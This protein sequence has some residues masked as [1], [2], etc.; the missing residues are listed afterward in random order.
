MIPVSKLLPSFATEH[1][2][3]IKSFIIK[4]HKW[5]LNFYFCFIRGRIWRIWAVTQICDAVQTWLVSLGV[6]FSVSRFEPA[7]NWNRFLADQRSGLN[8]L[9]SASV[10]LKS[11][12]SFRDILQST[13]HVKCWYRSRSSWVM[14]G[15]SNKQKTNKQTNR[16][17][18]FIYRGV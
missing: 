18:Y 10:C 5:K 6:V 9:N 15:Q 4:K 13:N 3:T 8:S 2:W 17:Y 7:L 11:N 1:C 16:D 14:I 12:Q